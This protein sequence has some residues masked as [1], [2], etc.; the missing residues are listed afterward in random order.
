MSV[1]YTDIF[2]WGNKLYFKGYRNGERYTQIITGFQPEFFFET[3][4]NSD[5]KTLDGRNLRRK[6][7]ENIKQA[8]ADLKLQ[9]T[10]RTVYGNSDIVQQ[11]ILKNFNNI[12]FDISLIKIAYIDIETECE[13]GFPHIETASERINAI[14]IHMND[15]TYVWCLGKVEMDVFYLRCFDSER[16]MLQDFLDTFPVLD[17]DILS[18]WNIQFFDI[19]YIV[20]RLRNLG[21]DPKF[22]SENNILK[23][24]EV[25]KTTMYGKEEVHRVYEITGLTVI[26]YMELIKDMKYHPKRF[27]S[28]SLHNVCQTVLETGKLDY[29]EYDNIKD[30]YTKNFQKFIEYNI[31]DA[32]LVSDLEKKLKLLQIV[33]ALAYDTK[34]TFSSIFYATKIWETVCYDFLYK[35]GIVCEIKSV[36][37][38]TEKFKGAIVKPV[39]PGFYKN[40]V[41]LDATSLYP[42][43]IRSCNISPEMLVRDEIKPVTLEELDSIHVPENCCLC[44]NGAKFFRESRGFIPTLIT[45]V[46]EERVQAK[47]KMLALEKEQ[48]QTGDKSKKAEIE[49]LDILQKVKKVL[50]NSLYGCLGTPNFI[51]FDPLLPTAVTFTGQL[52]LQT[53]IKTVN[54]H[55]NAIAKNEDPKDYVLGADTDSVYVILDDFIPKEIISEGEQ[56]IADFI[57]K[58]AKE[59]V[60]DKLQENLKV[61]MKKLNSFEDHIFFKREMIIL[62]ALFVAKKNYAL[63]VIDKEGVR[64][65]EAKEEI[66]GLRAVK[67]DVPKFVREKL[68]KII[69][70]ILSRSNQELIDLM[71]EFKKEFMEKPIE[72]IATPKTC[73]NLGKYSSKENIYQKGT[74]CAVRAA[75]IYNYELEKRGIQNKYNSIQEGEKIKFV[76]LKVPNE[77]GKPG[78][79][80]EWFGFT[81]RIPSEMPI[82]QYVDKNAQWEKMVM[83]PVE[84]FVRHIGWSLTS[85]PNLKNLFGKR[86]AKI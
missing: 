76:P 61:L 43:I 54:E 15:Q 36:G 4:E 63:W 38:K 19:P 42:S 46:F 81:G 65:K 3:H 69:I 27:D 72:D 77:F 68:R 9:R 2:A 14:S 7:Y 18:G 26:D 80:A 16:E 50:A 51:F 28:Y 11:F 35:N 5:Y 39:I 60:Q 31:R 53:A 58:F 59:H 79:E 25:T 24:R 78:I 86:P 33:I 85:K 17:I 64:R 70:I 30:F 84:S 1:F 10:M 20:Q 75:L 67:S 41:S 40:L 71:K 49:Y 47:T 37:I 23:E 13:A 8:K 74:P 48:E 44:G 32:K 83:A 73:N 52:I 34:V 45:K 22:L 29:S 82:Q 21:F 57:E 56:K 66:K 12:N 62:S 6:S 55:L